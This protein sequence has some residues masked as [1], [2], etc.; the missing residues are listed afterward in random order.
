MNVRIATSNDIPVIREIA[1]ATWPLAYGSILSREQLEYM[2]E[3]IYSVPSLEEQ[4][5]H[6]HHFFIFEKDKQPVGFASCNAVES[7]NRWK[8]QKL[9]VLP[10]TQK[11]GAGKALLE[12]VITTAK[13]HMA[14]E[15]ILNVNRNNPAY[16]YYL[17]NGFEVIET[18]DIPIGSGFY[19][20]DYVMR[21]KL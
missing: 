10:D 5:S 12:R 1:Y 18:V 17:K 7:H 15:L 3:L 2:L 8:L 4:F 14:T 11:S 21:R 19:M 16:T 13:E 6:H 9:Y 20:N